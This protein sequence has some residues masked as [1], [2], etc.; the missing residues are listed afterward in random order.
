MKKSFTQSE[1]LKIL[2][3][4]AKGKAL[5]GTINFPPEVAEIFSKV[6]NDPKGILAFFRFFGVEPPSEEEVEKFLK[7]EK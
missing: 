5:E 1:V 7:K 2:D 3:D 4:A 6:R